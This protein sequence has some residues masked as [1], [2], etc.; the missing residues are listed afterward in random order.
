[1]VSYFRAVAVILLPRI[2]ITNKVNLLLTL[3]LI[4][5]MVLINEII[6]VLVIMRV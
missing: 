3:Q 2:N 4:I 5:K 6:A 1:M